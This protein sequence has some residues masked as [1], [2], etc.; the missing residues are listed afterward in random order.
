MNEPLPHDSGPQGGR[1]CSRCGIHYSSKTTYL[2]CFNHGD[3]L[4]AWVARYADTI[5]S[6]RGHVPDLLVE[7]AEESPSSCPAPEG[8]KSQ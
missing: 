8:G 7:M 2:P 4:Q 6:L 3:N 1:P 5:L